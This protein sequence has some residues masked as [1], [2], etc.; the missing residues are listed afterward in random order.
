MIKVVITG[1]S[2]GFGYELLN[3]YSA[4]GC[5][6]F[7]LVR[8]ADSASLL[9]KQFSNC[10]PITADLSSDE[11]VGRIASVLSEYTDSLDILINNAGISGRE[12][13]IEAVR[14]EE[15]GSFLIFIAW[16]R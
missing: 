16:G 6:T 1:A 14:T 12:Y 13:R 15:E 2:R 11:A 5:M 10:Y 4:N 3:V 9:A 7:P 8:N